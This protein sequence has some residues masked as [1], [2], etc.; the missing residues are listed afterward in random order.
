MTGTYPDKTLFGSFEF[1]SLAVFSD[2]VLRIWS[3]A[4]LKAE[5]DT[6]NA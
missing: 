6:N 1:L 5:P 4:F 2:F 3:F